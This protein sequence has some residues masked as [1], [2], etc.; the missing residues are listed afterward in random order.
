MTT[1]EVSPT[2]ALAA[3]EFDASL[4]ALQL[5]S[6]APGDPVVTDLLWRH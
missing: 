1:D 3:W 5:T 2:P 6:C 4:C